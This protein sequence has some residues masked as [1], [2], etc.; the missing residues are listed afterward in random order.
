MITRILCIVFLCVVLGY[1]ND[2]NKIVL[3][4]SYGKVINEKSNFLIS[5]EYYF[6]FL[7]TDEFFK[8]S[9]LGGNLKNYL[10]PS[11][12]VMNQMKIYEYKKLG[13]LLGFSGFI[14]F[15]IISSSIGVDGE[16][17]TNINRYGYTFL[18]LSGFSGI[19]G[20]SCYLTCEKSLI[21]A[22]HLHNNYIN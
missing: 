14:L 15:G 11:F 2:F 21:K 13:C 7:K 16:Y 20:I 8:L 4:D 9:F 10:Y 17:K 22:I 1:S 5:S 19:I 12:D 3:L 18:G 6:Y